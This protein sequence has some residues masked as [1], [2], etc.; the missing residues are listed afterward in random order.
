MTRRFLVLALLALSLAAQAQQPALAP[1][2]AAQVARGQLPV[3]R[4]PSLG[5]QAYVMCHSEYLTLWSAKT[6]TPLW[7]A[8]YLTPARIQAARGRPRTN[9]FHETQGLPYGVGAR[10]S[11]YSRSGY[12]RGH[13]APNGD[14][15][16]PQ[17]QS[18]SFD[19][20]NIAPQDP[21]HNR[22]HWS[23]LEEATRRLAL[24]A[25]L[26]VV[27]GVVF[28]GNQIGFLKGRVAVPTAFYKLVY[29][30]QRQAASAWLMPNTA[31]AP[32]QVLTV[33]QLE[34]ITQVDYRLGP[35]RPLAL[36]ALPATD[37]VFS[38]D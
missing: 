38:G 35:V 3:V 27:T 11:D 24:R 7:S 9:D 34:A 4:N 23:K 17:A 37:P 1:A 10:L 20:S 16:T 33:A 15:S 31:T 25:P 21:T 28:Q 26:Y 8:E 2:C 5:Q 30:P 19:L 29:D 32:A 6:R 12:D 13:L 36:P 18:E 14:M 22:Y